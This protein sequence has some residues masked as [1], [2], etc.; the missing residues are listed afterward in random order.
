MSTLLNST[1]L[2]KLAFS[3]IPPR[4]ILWQK[5]KD[6]EDN[7]DGSDSITWDTPVEIT[8]ITQAVDQQNYK[9]LGLDFSKKYMYVHA[10][11]DLKDNA[12]QPVPDRLIFDGYVWNIISLSDWYIYNKWTSCMVGQD[13]RYTEGDINANV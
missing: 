2:L 5:Y 1:N 9:A 7:E 8:A 11:A 10:L 13:K 3:V 4:K 12:L 6:I